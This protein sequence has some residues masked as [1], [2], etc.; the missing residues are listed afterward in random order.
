MSVT[1]TERQRIPTSGARAVAAFTVDGYDLLAIPQLAY[2]VAGEVAGMN[3]G[4]ST[5]ELL[6]FVR[7]NDRYEP[8]AALSAPGGEDAEFFTID[9][10]AFLAVASIR[11]GHGPYVFETDSQIF[12][13]TGSGFEPF[14]RI[15]GYAA[16]QWRHWTIADRHFLG[17]AQGVARP[18]NDAEN[19]DS[20]VYEWD[21]EQFVEHQHIPSRWAYNWHAFAIGDDCFVAHADHVDASVLYRWDGEKLQAV[22]ALAGQ[23]GRAFAS[24]DASGAHYLVVACIAAPTRVLRWTGSQFETVQV[25]EGLGGRELAVVELADRVLV[26]RI[27]FILG[28]PA[29]PY[30]L[31]ASQIYEWDGAAL[32]VV[33]EFP[34]CGGTDASVRVRGDHTAE[35]IVTNAL[36]PELRFAAETVRYS[37]TVGRD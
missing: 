15:T 34:T 29:E 33:T 10:R 17:L 32:Q 22:Q 24:F 23:S 31:L 2:D 1:L 37:L 13:W 3:A 30:P 8:W 19:R 12:E 18:G 14:Q 35:L 25:L 36:T 26:V 5:T 11:T 9:G 28:T 16:K 20:I 27:N 21:G 4:D 6:L 7:R